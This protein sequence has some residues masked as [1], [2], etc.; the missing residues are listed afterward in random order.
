MKYEDFAK[1]KSRLSHNYVTS[2][3]IQNDIINNKHLSEILNIH[4]SKIQINGSISV[5]E[6]TTVYDKLKDIVIFLNKWKA[7]SH[8]TD[9]FYKSLCETYQKLGLINKPILNEW[10][11]L[12]KDLEMLDFVPYI[13]PTTNKHNNSTNIIKSLYIMKRENKYLKHKLNNLK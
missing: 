4:Y 5:I 2:L 13:K 8:N 9:T 7:D 6:K 12:K 10:E 3:I 11:S 1:G